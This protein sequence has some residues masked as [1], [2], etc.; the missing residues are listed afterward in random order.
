MIMLAHYKKY[1][2][3]KLLKFDW[4]LHFKFQLTLTISPEIC[5]PLSGGTLQRTYYTARCSA[6]FQPSKSVFNGL[7][8]L[9]DYSDMCCT[10]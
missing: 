9:L 6:A 4:K 2:C 3:N 7:K 8:T 1:G 5:S 10:L